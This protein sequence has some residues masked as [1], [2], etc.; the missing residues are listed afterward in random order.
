MMGAIERAARAARRLYAPADAQ[1]PA[2]EPRTGA[3]G[4]GV[5]DEGCEA[6]SGQQQGVVEA[7]QDGGE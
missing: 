4:P 6:V 5:P 7:P 1:E 3:G 2:Q